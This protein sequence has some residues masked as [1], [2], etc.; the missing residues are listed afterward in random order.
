[1]QEL[2]GGRPE[3]EPFRFTDPTREASAPRWRP[4]SRVLSFQSRR[5]PETT[6]A[7]RGSRG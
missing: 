7:Q 5:E 2:R 6:L 1:M 4:D 3:G